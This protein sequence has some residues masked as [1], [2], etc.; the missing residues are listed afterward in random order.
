MQ[1]PSVKTLRKFYVTDEKG[2]F[3]RDPNGNRINNGYDLTGG[4][5]REM[6]AILY[7]CKQAFER[8]CPAPYSVIRP[9]SAAISLAEENCIDLDVDTW[10]TYI[11]ETF[12]FSD[13]N[14]RM[15]HTEIYEA[16]EE[17]KQMH[18][19]HTKLTNFAKRDIRRLL[20]VAYKC[21]RKN[22]HNVK[23]LTGIKRKNA[24]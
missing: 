16:I 1:E 17:T 3:I 24:S 12:D 4:L 10:R 14:S 18:S 8:V 2:N 7:K 20:T 6:P 22:I 23:Y 5:V 11:D 19:D 21:G 9:S 15:L 13:P